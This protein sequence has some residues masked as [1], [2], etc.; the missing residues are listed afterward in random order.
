M[1]GTTEERLL[2]LIARIYDA[3]V[4]GASWRDF[5]DDLADAYSGTAAISSQASIGTGT[6][7]HAA[8]RIDPAFGRAYEEY[9]S[10]KRPWVNELTVI[11][12]GQVFTPRRLVRDLNYE[13]SEY[14]NDWLKPQGIYYLFSAA[15]EIEGNRSTYLTIS[16]SRRYGDFSAEEFDL[17]YKLVPHLQRAMLMHRHVFDTMRQRDAMAITLEGLGVGAILVTINGRVRFVN[18]VAEA[19]LR[20]ENGLVQRQGHLRASTPAATNALNRLIAEAASI[21]AGSG[22]GS[23]GVLLVP[24]TQASHLHVLV[25]PVPIGGTGWLGLPAPMA[26]VIV[27]EP[28]RHLALRASELEQLYGLTP[29][30]ANLATALVSGKTLKEYATASRITLVTAKTHLQSIFNKT[31]WHRQSDL[32]RGTLA[33]GIA[34]MA[35]TLLQGKSPNDSKG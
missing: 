12:P 10:Q 9:Y 8:S 6:S 14:Y 32:V 11:A 34:Q 26:L 19:L 17:T 23:G 4:G 13:K 16:R 2:Q 29:A 24:R 28:S 30:E 7:I 27:S 20:R 21:G 31:G 25:C 3:A 33:N 18:Q 1:P 35:K 5:V 22:A 15:L